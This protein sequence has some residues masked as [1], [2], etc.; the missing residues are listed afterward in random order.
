MPTTLELTIPAACS[1]GKGI[2]AVRTPSTQLCETYLKEPFFL[3][4]LGQEDG[5][6]EFVDVCAGQDQ[7]GWEAKV[8]AYLWKDGDQVLYP[9]LSPAGQLIRS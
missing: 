5:V 6:W 9:F 7:Q 1:R 2:A 3:W 8:E 4:R